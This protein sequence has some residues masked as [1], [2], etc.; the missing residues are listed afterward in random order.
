MSELDP[1][2]T[3]GNRAAEPVVPASLVGAGPPARA[4]LRPILHLR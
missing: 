1:S 3:P 2:Q 4:M